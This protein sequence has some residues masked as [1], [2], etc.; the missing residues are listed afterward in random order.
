MDSSIPFTEIGKKCLSTKWKPCSVK[1]LFQGGRIQL[2]RLREDLDLSLFPLQLNTAHSSVFGDITWSIS[3]DKDSCSVFTFS[4]SLPGRSRAQFTVT[5]DQIGLFAKLSH[6]KMF[7]SGSLIRFEAET[8]P[9]KPPKFVCGWR[10]LWSPLNAVSVS[11]SV[12]YATELN[13]ECAVKFGR[14]EAFASFGPADRFGLTTRVGPVDVGASG[15]I[16]DSTYSTRV[17]GRLSCCDVGADVTICDN[18]I[19]HAVG[20]STCVKGCD[21]RVKTATEGVTVRVSRDIREMTRLSL[22]CFTEGLSAPKCGA[23]LVVWD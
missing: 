7:Q 23:E 14:C 15:S 12:R 8:A 10:S 2:K 21:L 13:L 19:S 20:V 6:E 1:Y 4:P 17:G 18:R 11:T 22:S 16:I 3:N 9:R 5:T